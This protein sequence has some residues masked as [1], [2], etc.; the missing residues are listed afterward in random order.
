MYSS[1]LGNLAIPSNQLSESIALT[2]KQGLAI[3]TVAMAYGF[4]VIKKFI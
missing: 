1:L 4:V 3:V 2:L